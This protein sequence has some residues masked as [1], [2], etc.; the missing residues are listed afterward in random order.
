MVFITFWEVVDAF[1][2]VLVIGYIF[3]DYLSLDNFSYGGLFRTNFYYTSYSG[4]QDL[5]FAAKIVAP[6]IIL[7]ELGHKLIALIFGLDATF[8]AAYIWLFIGLL[9]KLMNFGFIFFVPAYVSILGNPTPI[10]SFF[11][12]LAGP[13]TNLLIFLFSSFMLKNYF[14]KM[15]FASK[16]AWHLSKQINFILFIFNLIPIP[17]FDGFKA[18]MSLVSIFS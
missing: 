3:K 6:A 18:L 5:L 16:V 1:I 9:L 15:D 11:I 14:S 7:H 8:H 4:W 2:I 12:S 13:F 17:G 10:E